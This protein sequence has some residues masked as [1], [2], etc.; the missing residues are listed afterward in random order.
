MPLT[1]V[2]D[3]FDISTSNEDV[4]IINIE[5]VTSVPD[6]VED[7]RQ[8]EKNKLK[9]VI[10]KDSFG[11][12]KISVPL[13]DKSFTVS[14]KN[15][16]VYVYFFGECMFSQEYVYLNTILSMA[17]E[18]AEVEVYIDSPGGDLINALYLSQSL[19][20]TKAKTTAIACGKV[21]SAAT[22]IFDACDNKVINE[23]S[24]FM[25]HDF[26]TGMFGKGAV[27]TEKLKLS[28]QALKENENSLLSTTGNPLRKYL[29][30]KDLEN[31][32][33]GI[34]IYIPGIEIN[35]RLKMGVEYV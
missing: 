26:S 25:F 12:E 4:N 20:N 2:L 6:I 34:D 14:V 32:N 30:K 17:D 21:M 22:M 29:N 33:I 28:S 9:Q 8:E 13:I 31:F 11:I 10:S 27:M 15:N 1:D 7:K 23:F 24:L 16:K 35:R 18:N 19:K 3:D 5:E